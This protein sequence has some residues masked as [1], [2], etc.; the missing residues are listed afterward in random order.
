MKHS[1]RLA[2]AALI[3]VLGLAACKSEKPAAV[4]PFDPDKGTTAAEGEVERFHRLWNAD[5]FKAVYDDAHEKLRKSQ[6]AEEYVAKLEQVKGNYGAFK[7]TKKR[8]SGVSSD[9]NENI[10]KLSYDSTY[11]RGS[12]VEVFAYRMT[13][14][15]ALLYSYDIMSPEEAKKQ[16]AE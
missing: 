12:A 4:D 1:L 10:I 2:G 11:E 16:E 13:T 7:S 8:R 3:L 9:K 6:T 14:Y 15:R 5:E